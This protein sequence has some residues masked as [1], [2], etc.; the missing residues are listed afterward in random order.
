MQ[1]IH[2]HIQST[3]DVIQSVKRDKPGLKK[4]NKN[5]HN[6]YGGVK[7]TQ[8][9]YERAPGSR[10]ECRTAPDGCRPLHQANG[11]QP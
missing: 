10:D 8:S 1:R 11:L 2:V 3:H 6:V 4:Y 5:Q 7:M 9:H